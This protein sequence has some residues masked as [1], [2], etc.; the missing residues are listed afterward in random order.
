MKGNEWTTDGAK[1]GG[2]GDPENNNGKI[3]GG[4]PEIMVAK[5]NSD[6]EPKKAAEGNSPL[7]LCAF[8]PPVMPLQSQWKRP[9]FS[10]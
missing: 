3:R 8:P 6:T 10:S 1:S 4:K 2:G 5:G 9:T 7:S